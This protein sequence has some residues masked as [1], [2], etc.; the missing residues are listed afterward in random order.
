MTGSF[1]VQILGKKHLKPYIPDFKLAFE[2]F[3]IHTGW[4]PRVCCKSPMMNMPSRQ[5]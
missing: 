3:C 4:V 2:H 1:V 5:S